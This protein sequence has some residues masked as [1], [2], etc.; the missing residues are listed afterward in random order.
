MV[1]K[2]AHS[3]VPPV[4][5]GPP[6]VPAPGSEI[7]LCVDLDDT[8]VRTDCSWEAVAQILFRHPL[9]LLGILRGCGRGRAWMKRQISQASPLPVESLPYNA[10]VLGLITQAKSA[11]RKVLLVTASDQL[12]ADR[13]AAH[14]KLF[15]EAIGS[16]GVTNL[17]G[18]AKA[19]L[20]VKKFGRGGFDYAGD[21]AADIPVWEAARQAY[22]VN[23]ASAARRWLAQRGSVTTLGAARGGWPGLARALW[24][25]Q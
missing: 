3:P 15:D 13:V 21:S 9:R 8:L 4:P 19:E 7:P 1:A 22:A 11:G 18:A 17:K 6:Q 14:L 5:A 2:D 10:D 25:R 12:V 20:L 23:P 16:D 24:P